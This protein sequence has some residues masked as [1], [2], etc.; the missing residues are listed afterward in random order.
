MDG[1]R[2]K[3]RLDVWLVE[4]GLA[5]SRH[6]AQ[7]MILAGQVLVNEQRADKAGFP[8][9]P[10]AQVRIRGEALRYVGRG[11]LKLEGALQAFNLDVTGAVCLDVGASTGGFTDC[12]LQHGAVRVYAVDVGTNQLVWKLRTDE[13]VIAREHVNARFL[14]P[15]D[16]PEKFSVMTC[17]VSFISL[18]KILPPLFSLAV[19]GG[20]LLAL[21]KPQFEV[22]RSEVGKGGIV[23][24]PVLHRKVLETVVAAARQ[25]GFIPRRVMRSPIAGTDGN[26]EFLLWAEAGTGETSDQPAE[27]GLTSAVETDINALFG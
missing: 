27:P 6:K 13:R 7:G 15:D 10:D 24:D 21:V 18:E 14:K 5:E 20:I 2:K 9:G 16:F 12:L 23:R 17:D 1:P 26:V 22:G 8:V 25:N 19:P 3:Q 11:G 4:H